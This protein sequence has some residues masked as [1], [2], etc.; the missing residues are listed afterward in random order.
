L[1]SLNG[2]GDDAPLTP[3]SRLKLVVSDMRRE[4]S[5]NIILERDRK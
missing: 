4:P 2:L 3:G 1:A 5:T